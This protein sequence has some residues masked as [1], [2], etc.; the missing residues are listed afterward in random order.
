MTWRERCV[1]R[2]LLLVAKI[3]A[4]RDEIATEVQHLANHISQGPR[5]EG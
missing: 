5:E 4:D 2:I 3:V 1:C